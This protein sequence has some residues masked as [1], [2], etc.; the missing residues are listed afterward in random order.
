MKMKIAEW[1]HV[2]WKYVV[3]RISQGLHFAI[4]KNITDTT[5]QQR[6]IHI[7]MQKYYPR[8]FI[9]SNIAPVQVFIA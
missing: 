6:I 8:R 5:P 9:H 7:R 1:W 2:N 4:M 3:Y